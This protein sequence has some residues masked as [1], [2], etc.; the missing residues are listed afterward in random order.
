MLRTIFC[1]LEASRTLHSELNI[2]KTSGYMIARTSYGTKQSCHRRCKGQMPGLHS[3]SSRTS[4]VLCFME[5]T[6]AFKQQRVQERLEKVVR[7]GMFSNQSFIK[8]L[9]SFV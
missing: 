6:L 8:I 1:S 2:C 3:L 9:G 7:S 5:D 4:W